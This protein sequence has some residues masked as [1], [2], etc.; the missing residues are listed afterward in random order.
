MAQ[1]NLTLSQEEILQLLSAKNSSE[2]FKQMLKGSLNQFLLIESSSQLCAE[3][4]ER[5]EE[6]RDQRN[7][8][9]E[10]ELTTRLG[11][12]TL[13]VPR[14]RNLPFH[15]MLFENYERH[16]A[17][18]IV[19]MAEMVVSGV[20]TRKVAKVM[21]TLCGKEFSKSTV[22]EA[23]KTLDKEVEAFRNR[24][25]K[26]GNYPFLMVD[27]TYFKVRE[28]HRI[29]SKA[30]M[31]AIGITS[32]GERELIGFDVY[33]GENNASWGSFIQS[34]KDRGLSEVIM[35]TSDAHLSIRHA[36]GE[37]F[38]SS[39]WQRCQFHFIRN[40]LDAAPKAY[41]IGLQTELREMFS[42]KTLKEARKRR[43]EILKD[44]QDIAAKAMGILDEGFE[45][46]MT[47]M[48]LPKEMQI[49]LRT[50][51]IV[52]RLNGELKRRSKAIGIFPN[53]AS[54]LRL[55]GSVAI[56]YHEAQSRKRNL[57]YSTS[58]E[59]ILPETRL[60]LITV[61]KEQIKLAEAA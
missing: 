18:L 39:A 22:S 38:P 40:I 11:T 36:M 44:Y 57:F 1:V 13:S 58:M 54:V 60:K 31:T 42:C 61:A 45:D 25:L 41:R 19:T 52:E 37:K 30:F 55:M 59:K 53:Q 33:E 49:P 21:E 20:S 24:P 26:P 32:L 51:N 27:A 8:T 3:P 48:M 14:H 9:R 47:V 28:D 15:S 5:T 29:V 50:S 6:R 4:Y 2:A 35:Y 10:R 12:I 46:S 23:C 43:D 17:A 16:E 56:A 34:L 7:G